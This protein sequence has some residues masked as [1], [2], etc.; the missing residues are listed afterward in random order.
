MRHGIFYKHASFFQFFQ[1]W[2]NTY[3]KESIQ[4]FKTSVSDAKK[5]TGSIPTQQYPCYLTNEHQVLSPVVCIAGEAE[6]PAQHVS[7]LVLY[8]YTA[9]DIPHLQRLA[10]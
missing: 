2:E 4:I 3:K 9:G 5:G 7:G 10:A 8:K 1:K 6:G